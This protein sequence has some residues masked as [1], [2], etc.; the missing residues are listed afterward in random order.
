MAA[1]PAKTCQSVALRSP[2]GRLG[3]I[4]Y[5]CKRLRRRRH[6]FELWVAF[7]QQVG[8]L[9]HKTYVGRPEGDQD[10]IDAMSLLGSG[11]QDSNQLEDA[12]AVKEAELATLRRFGAS[13][14]R[15]LATQSNLA[16]TYAR[17]G[18]IEQALRMRRDVYTGYWKLKG[19]EQEETL[20]AASNYA[21]SLFY[22]QRFEENRALLRKTIPVARRVLGESR[23]I[24]L[25]MRKTY[26]RALSKDPAATL[27][28]L[29]EAVTTLEET[30]QTARRVLG[31]AHPLTKNVEGSLRKMRARLRARETPSRSA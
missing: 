20:I 7:S 6:R 31:G 1:A 26:G 21:I 8:P 23:E 14:E 22:L 19:E 4:L 3:S 25:K 28:D 10:R 18:K 11:L 9:D 16:N 5:T 13:E 12:S 27:D 30:E 15:N 17:L 24:T 29:R 2:W